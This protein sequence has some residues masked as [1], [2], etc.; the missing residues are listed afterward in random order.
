V[1]AR[2]LLAL[3][4]LLLLACPRDAPASRPPG[5]P[6]PSS[7]AA[8]STPAPTPA[9]APAPA[10]ALELPAR[11]ESDRVFLELHT[12]GGEPLRLY[13]DT[14]GGL[15]LHAHVAERLG[16][17]I[18]TAEG[19]GG[20]PIEVVTL[21]P[22]D[23]ATPMPPVAVLDGRLP[24]AREAPF[25]D[26]F[27][28]GML[29]QA[30]FRDRV[31]TLD[32]AAERLLLHPAA[33]GCDD[34][35]PVPLGFPQRDGQRT[36]HY[37]RIQATIDGQ[38]LD[39]LFDTGATVMLTDAGRA[40]LGDGGPAERATS[41]IVR[42]TFDR[43]RAE[44]PDW[45]VVEGADRMAGDPMIE[46]PRVT[47]GELSVGPVWFTA[48]DDPNFHDFMSRFMD[49]RVEGALGGSAFRGLRVTVD[50]PAAQACVRAG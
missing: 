43:W 50:Y 20:R 18:E 24:V 41:F 5:A 14:G 31:W 4:S 38:R 11:F 9:P 32:Y 17:P 49:R 12:A 10:P 25:G 29:G 3:G 33:I 16:L 30:W 42:S 35:E 28:D 8:A 47:L 34:G 44:H 21:P 46:V 39:L 27:G 22:M 15:Y 23:P 7:S 2:S 1:L 37:P 13:T 6:P 40:A 19:D 36:G 48:R 45:P 26:V